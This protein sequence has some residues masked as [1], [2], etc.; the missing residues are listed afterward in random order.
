[1]HRW[2]EHDLAD[3][4]K[5]LSGWVVPSYTLPP[6]A[7]TPIVRVCVRVGFS[8]QLAEKLIE[9]FIHACEYLVR[10]RRGRRKIR[11]GEIDGAPESVLFLS[12][13]AARA[14]PLCIP[15]PHL[16]LPLLP[17]RSLLT[18]SP[19]IDRL[20]NDRTRT[21]RPPRARRGSATTA[22]STRGPSRRAGTAP[23]PCDHA[24]GRV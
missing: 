15:S 24:G 6:P 19:N 21:T 22:S 8:M 3:R 11:G 12:P 4:L 7:A 9:D 16:L 13:P 18:Y 5:A 23:P 2:T 17:H 14:L 10:L 20:I 1:M